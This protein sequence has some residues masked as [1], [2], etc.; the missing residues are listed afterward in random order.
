MSGFQD[1]PAV[2]VP[3]DKVITSVGNNLEYSDSCALRSP[4]DR[5]NTSPDLGALGQSGTA[6]E[7]QLL[8]TT[9]PAVFV[10]QP[11]SAAIGNGDCTSNNKFD[12]RLYGRPGPNNSVCDIGAVEADGAEVV[13]KVDLA[14]TMTGN[15]PTVSL[16]GTVTYTLVVTNN[17]PGAAQGVTVTTQ[18]PTVAGFVFSVPANSLGVTCTASS[19][20]L[21]CNASSDLAVGASF[22]VFINVTPTVAPAG[23][24]L[25]VRARADAT[26][27]GDY[28][29]GNN[30]SLTA[31]VSGG[32][33][34]TG[35]GSNT[36]FGNVNGGGGAFS[37]L[38]LL[39]LATPGALLLRRRKTS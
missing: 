5:I 38:E 6:S 37:P 3:S 39:L 9:R 25:E 32:C 27:P 35:V 11:G 21:L 14:L 34:L 2:L 17:G 22:T 4:G 7:V 23:G 20:Q 12:Q 10:P 15:V 26:S 8:D 30:G 18:I 28:L 33:V 29:P 31:C 36:N 24:F 13:G 1:T 19:G 16:G